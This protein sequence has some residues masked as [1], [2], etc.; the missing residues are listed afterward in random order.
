ML[1]AEKINSLITRM[2]PKTICNKCINDKLG[3]TQQAHSAQNTAAL[4]TTSDFTRE[5]SLCSVCGAT[6]TVIRA[7]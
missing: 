3:L 6:K 1:I 4:G 5:K 2:R 7:S